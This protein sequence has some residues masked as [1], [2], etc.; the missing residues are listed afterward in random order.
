MVANDIVYPCEHVGVNSSNLVNILPTAKTLR[1][2]RKMTGVLEM[3]SGFFF[4]VLFVVFGGR[5]NLED[6]F[7][8]LFSQLAIG[9]EVGCELHD[10]GNH[11]IDSRILLLKQSLIVQDGG[12]LDK[13]CFGVIKKGPRLVIDGVV[14]LVWQLQEVVVSL[15]HE[16]GI[17]PIFSR[18]KILI[19]IKNTTFSK[20]LL[21]IL[22]GLE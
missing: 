16:T 13:F 14:F 5:S 10:F 22:D 12:N 17:K 4:P 11:C 8:L 2:K 20:Q 7:D 3:I 21:H 9:V 1:N 19:L 15:L 6:L 18:R